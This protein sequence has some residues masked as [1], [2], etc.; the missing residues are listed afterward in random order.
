MTSNDETRPDTRH[1]ANCGAGL[2][3]GEGIVLLNCPVCG[4]R[5]IGTATSEW[6]S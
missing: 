1:C 5:A 2:T 6:E 4:S 3:I